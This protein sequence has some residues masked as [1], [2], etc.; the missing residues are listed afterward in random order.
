MLPLRLELQPEPDVKAQLPVSV[1][2]SVPHGF[3]LQGV[4]VPAQLLWLRKAQPKAQPPPVARC[5]M[6]PELLL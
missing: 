6:Q 3:R 2:A 4:Q 5:R 1:R